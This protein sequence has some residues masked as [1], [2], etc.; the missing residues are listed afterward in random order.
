MTKLDTRTITVPSQ[1]EIDRLMFKAQQMRAD[2]IRKSFAA[3]PRWIAGLI[4]RPHFGTK[5]K[6]A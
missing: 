4:A 1:E 5:Q 2:Y 6:A 3:F